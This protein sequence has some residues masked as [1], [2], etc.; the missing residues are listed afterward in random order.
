[1]KFYD[2][3]RRASGYRQRAVAAM[4]IFA[5]LA[6]ALPPTASAQEAATK[7]FGR[8]LF[9]N[10][11]GALLA[12]GAVAVVALLR[13]KPPLRAD[14]RE[15]DF[16]R[17]AP[18]TEATRALV[19]TN[20]SK[21]PATMES[22]SVPEPFGLIAPFQGPREMAAGQVIT[23]ELTFKPSGAQRSNAELT[24]RTRAGDPAKERTLKIRLK[25]DARG[26]K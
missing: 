18:G 25:G 6:A 24:V 7:E 22:I 10:V 16:G 26:D 1:M 17:T 9:T 13:P 8:Q 5:L 14:A 23:I 19:L 11:A 2:T 4:V 15:V 21:H 12:A 20:T 3:P